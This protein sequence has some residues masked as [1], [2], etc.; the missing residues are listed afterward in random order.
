MQWRHIFAQQDLAQS[1][2]QSDTVQ[3]QFEVRESKLSWLNSKIEKLNKIAQKLKLPPVGYKVLKE[4]WVDDPN[5]ESKLQKIKLITIQIEGNTPIITTPSGQRWEFIA[6]I[7]HTDGGNVI[8]TVPGAVDENDQSFKQFRSVPP[9]CE[10]CGYQRN[11]KDTFLLRNPDNKQYK[12]VGSSCLKDFL[13][14]KSANDYAAWAESLADLSLS[15]SADD[16]K[17]G[18]GRG[19]Q[20][21]AFS[22]ELWL[23]LVYAVMKGATG[24]RFISRKQQQDA[25]ARGQTISTTADA[26][27]GLL[28]SKRDDDKKLL[29]HYLSQITP[30]DS[31]MLEDALAWARSLKD[32]DE[33]SVSQLNDYLWNLSVAASQPVVTRR[34]WGIVA[35][36]P[37]TYERN[38]LQKMAVKPGEL[39]GAKGSDFVGQVVIQFSQQYDDQILYIAKTADNK[40]VQWYSDDLGVELG[41]QINIK[42]TIM[43]PSRSGGMISTKL[44]R[45]RVLDESQFQ[46]TQ[47]SQQQIQPVNEPAAPTEYKIGQNILSKVFIK[48]VDQEEDTYSRYPKY[49]YVYT[50]EDMGGTTLKWRTGR[51]FGLEVGEKITFEGQV[52]NIWIAPGGQHKVVWV[53]SRKQNPI[54]AREFEGEEGKEDKRLKPDELKALKKQISVLDKQIKLLWAETGL[55][56]KS[57]VDQT[58]NILRNAFDWL[59]SSGN[60][61]SSFAGGVNPIYGISQKLTGSES[62]G[63]SPAGLRLYNFYYYLLRHPEHLEPIANEIDEALQSKFQIESQSAPAREEKEALDAQVQSHYRPDAYGQL[64]EPTRPYE[65]HIKPEGWEQKYQEDKA[66][67]EQ[68]ENTRRKAWEIQGKLYAFE[69]FKSQVDQ[70]HRNKDMLVNKT[71]QVI[72]QYGPGIIKYVELYPQIKQL[73]KQREP[74]DDRMYEHKQMVKEYGERLARSWLKR[75]IAD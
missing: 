28:F 59:V 19:R 73:E 27:V 17:D 15:L 35:A 41:S 32:A 2:T 3:S 51:D 66:N 33:Q 64:R 38:V 31:N 46:S 70:F 49:N 4:E 74:L 6:R 47:Q 71:K 23:N 52:K 34:T 13:G 57:D 69:S 9:K 30:E 68:F 75:I 61:L 22:T 37:S 1:S 5:D 42:G 39:V 45:V 25:Q 40:S 18:F 10:H 53:V 67:Y 7:L 56:N 43:G 16:E 8:K 21:H 54:K 50:M 24:G 55:K 58:D 60:I 48:K 14:H 26:A 12:Q 20:E 63:S 36:L 11:R 44:A 65:P 72:D 62:L 29:Q